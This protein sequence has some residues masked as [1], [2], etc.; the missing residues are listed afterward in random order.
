MVDEFLK[1]QKDIETK[2]AEKGFLEKEIADKKSEISL[3]KDRQVFVDEALIVFQEVAQKT[4]QNL[5]SHFS[6]L[7]TLALRSVWNFPL[8]FELKVVTR[9]NKTE[10]D[11]LLKEND[12]GE[13]DPME[14]SAG[15]TLDVASFALRVAFW[16]LKRNRNTLILD[17]PFRNVS[18]DLQ[19]K[20]SIMVK[21]ISKELKLQIIMVSHAEEINY[22]AD[23]IFTVSKKDGVSSVRSSKD[24]SVREEE[25]VSC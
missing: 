18:P 17:E 3:L 24:C 2:K 6:E 20:I 13:E 4:Q 19:D 10:V 5:E 16:S 7:V 15:G 9:R 1:I 22:S 23:K 21:K 12:Q 11:F 14:N 25:Q 8:D